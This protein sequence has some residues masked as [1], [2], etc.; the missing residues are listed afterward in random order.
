MKPPKIRTITLE[1][2]RKLKASALAGEKKKHIYFPRGLVYFDREL[3]TALF[4]YQSTMY[5]AGS[6]DVTLFPM[7]KMITVRHTYVE[8]AERDFLFGRYLYNGI[9]LS[10]RSMYYNGFGVLIARI[11]LFNSSSRA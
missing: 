10:T 6:C 8:E 9:K 11:A 4:D 5:F 1:E 7:S 2:I 3:F